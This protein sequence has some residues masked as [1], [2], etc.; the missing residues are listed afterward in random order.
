M[1]V[2]ADL[3]RI[4]LDRV[5]AACGA[6]L[7]TAQQMGGSITVT[8][9]APETTTFAYRLSISSRTLATFNFTS[10]GGGNEERQSLSLVS[11]EE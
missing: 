11:T 1:A 3:Y 10:P 5:R 6:S 4:R 8:D 2:S 7:A 9:N